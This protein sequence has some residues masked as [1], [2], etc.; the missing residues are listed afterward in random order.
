MA[1]ETMNKTHLLACAVLLAGLAAVPGA[2]A[3]TCPRTSPPVQTIA[4]DCV[5][6]AEA[7]TASTIAEAQSDVGTGVRLV[8][9]GIGAGRNSYGV[10]ATVL[11]GAVDDGL[12]VA[13]HAGSYAGSVERWGEDSAVVE[14]GA[15]L[16]FTDSYL[17]TSTPQFPWVPPM[18]PTPV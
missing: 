10:V 13:N 17:C 14:L 9:D 1:R 15:V 8:Q 12:T 3:S 2:T 18:P 6:Y 4:T 11:V 7:T 5:D 16:C